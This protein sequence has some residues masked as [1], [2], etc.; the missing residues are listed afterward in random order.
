MTSHH[1]TA[2]LR[3]I[4]VIKP[5]SLGDVFHAL[6]TVHQL[7]A[8][9]GAAIH[10]V[11]NAP[12]VPLVRCFDPVDRV[13]SFP[14]QAFWTNRGAFLADLRRERYDLV[15][16][17]QGLMKSALI[18]RAARAD[19]ILGPSFHREGSRCLYHAVAGRRNKQRHAVEEN[20]DM[21]DALGI[22]R[23]EVAFPATF[24]APDLPPASGLRIGVIPRSRWDTKN[25]PVTHF[26]ATCEGL[27]RE[28]NAAIHLFGAPEDADTCAELETR[29]GGAA[30]NLCGQTALPELAGWLKA[31]D[32]VLC[33]DTG[34]MHI[35]AAVGAPVLAV[36][37]ATDPLRTG[38][39][40]DRNRVLVRE[41]LPCRPCLART[42]RL[43]ERDLRCLTGLEP[44][45]VIEAARAILGRREPVA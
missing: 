14:R 45:R 20:L 21:L 31:M 2:D 3:R 39:Y 41:D 17:M 28:A 42:C 24:P 19:R 30:R 26:A 7:K 10:W 16:D 8:H 43:P 6:P 44:D 32:L 34:P 23:G 9:T 12:Y 1:A 25:W 27:I 29:L 38:P 40:G 15:L 37:G 36:F 18:A 13:L 4:L 5:S 11:A 33:V 22:P 35:A